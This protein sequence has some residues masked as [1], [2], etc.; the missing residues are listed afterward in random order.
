MVLSITGSSTGPCAACITAEAR[1]GAFRSGRRKGSGAVSETK[2]YWLSGVAGF[3]AAAVSVLTFHQG[4]V[5]LLYVLGQ[6][7]APPYSFAAVGPLAVPRVLDLCFWGGLYGLLFGLALPRL[8]RAPLW[9]M[10]LVLGLIAAMVGWFVVAPL[11][12]Q[13]IAGGWSAPGMMRSVLIN[14]FWGLGVGL[15][16]GFLLP[17]RRIRPAP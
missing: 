16:L 6:I 12:G 3:L 15:I 13:P 7:P 5:G 9:L 8:S 10:G 2:V 4:M 1:A 11:R 14:G 17:R